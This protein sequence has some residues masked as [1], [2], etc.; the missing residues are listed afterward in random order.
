MSVNLRK[1]LNQNGSS[2]FRR[3]LIAPG[4]VLAHLS[5]DESYDDSKLFYVSSSP[6]SITVPLD[7]RG[8]TKERRGSVK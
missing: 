1:L 3:I 2:F 7:A 6:I 4:M 8:E 5:Y